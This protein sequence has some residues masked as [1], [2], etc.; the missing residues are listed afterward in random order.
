M[1]KKRAIE[2]PSKPDR[3]RK[4]FET[5]AP[6][7]HHLLSLLVRSTL[8]VSPPEMHHMPAATR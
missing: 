1:T 7:S 3:S 2:A 5:K 4:K 8:L 6:S